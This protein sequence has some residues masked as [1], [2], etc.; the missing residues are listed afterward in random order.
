MTL[1]IL[2]PAGNL[3]PRIVSGPLTL[4][5]LSFHAVASLT[6]SNVM[7]IGCC[8]YGT[9]AS[10]L[11]PTGC[12]LCGGC[13]AVFRSLL[14]PAGWL[15]R[16]GFCLGGDGPSYFLADF[17]W[18][19]AFVLGCELPTISGCVTADAP[20]FVFPFVVVTRLA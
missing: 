8:L 18:V 19:F 11:R 14:L 1:W 4:P 16:L 9:V 6:E 15:A 3:G 10:G 2:A 12:S 20:G 17:R 5:M 7:K 13:G